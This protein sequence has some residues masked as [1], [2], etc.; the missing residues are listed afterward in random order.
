MYLGYET[1]KKY[2]ILASGSNGTERCSYYDDDYSDFYY[3]YYRDDD[4]YYRDLDDDY[5]DDY[6]DKVIYTDKYV[7]IQL[8]HSK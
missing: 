3:W 8:L 7:M 6:D 2:A 5:D 4:M 1:I